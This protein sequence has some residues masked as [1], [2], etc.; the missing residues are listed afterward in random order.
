MTRR[1]P[2]LVLALWTVAGLLV[3]LAAGLFGYGRFGGTSPTTAAPF[4]WD[5]A[6]PLVISH[7]AGITDSSRCEVRP[8]GGEP[9]TF[10][11]NRRS[12]GSVRIQV[13]Q[14]WFD[15]RAEVTC[16][17][18]K[19]LTGPLARYVDQWFTAVLLALVVVM[20]SAPVLRRHRRRQA[21]GP[22]AGRAVP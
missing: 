6:G 20:V 18:A 16:E 22:P 11:V 13:E 12:S 7:H 2:P 15:G 14:P 8:A 5:G 3:L 4:Q 9:R 17:R 1:H 10:E 21:G 19:L